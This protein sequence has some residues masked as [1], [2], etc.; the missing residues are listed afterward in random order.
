[1]EIDLQRF[2]AF[3]KNMLAS[4]EAVKVVQICRILCILEN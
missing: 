3:I 4:V 2:G 1:V